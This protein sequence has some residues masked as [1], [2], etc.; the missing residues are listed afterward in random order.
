MAK[1]KRAVHERTDDWAQL[2]RLLK[3]PDQV[4]YELIRPVVVFGETAG[5]RAQATGAS[6]RT[7]DRQADRFDER[8]MLGLLPAPRRE[9]AE[10]PRGLP[11]PMRQ[12]IVDLRAEVPGMSL[13]EIA[14]VCETQFGRR[15][16]HHTVKKVL[17]TGPAPSRTTRRF[18]S[19]AQTSDPIQRRLAVVRLHA[20]GWRVSTIARYLETTPRTV[21]RTLER[22]V[23]E[24]FAGLA[25]KSHAPTQPA[26]KVTLAV[27]NEV[28]KLQQN[29]ELGEWRMHAALLQMG[30]AVS[31]R[32]CGRIMARNRALYGLGKPR[33]SP[34]SKKEM[35]YKAGRR[36]EYWSIDIRYIE[37]HQLDD[38]EPVFVIS[39][40]ENYSRAV[41]ASALSPTQDLLAVLVVVYEALRRCGAPE[42]IVSDGGA[43]FRAKQLLHAYEALGIRREQIPQG[44]PWTNYIE[45]HFGIMRRLAD[46]EFAR[47]ATWEEMLAAHERFV[48]DYNAQVHWAHRDRQDRRHSPAAVLGWVR[49][50]TYP[51]DV[52]HRVLYAVQFT[53]HVDRHGYIRFRHWRLYGERGLAG[54]P[55]SVWV[56]DGSLRLEYQTVLLAGY[57]VVL[58]GDGKHIRE[59]RHPRLAETRFRSPQLALF[60]L[61][62]DEWLLA[63]RLPE[64]APRRR[65]TLAGPVQLPLLLEGVGAV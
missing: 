53:R 21:Y 25:D 11:P 38:P 20:E 2:R 15:P 56:Y 8:G 27:A 63:L 4:V 54:A 43:V 47:A 55:V 48:R 51:E 40:L 45:S 9:P 10:D 34:R 19:Y 33:R 46:Y 50:T 49:G 35:P 64:Y 1:R 28:R 42:V 18:P 12:R 41:L 29:P 58:Q 65:G 61:G 7:I 31:P 37:K 23:A 44:Q 57:S 26:T 24:Q 60:H 52:L 16:S 39:I 36:H 3:W 59:V 22:W 32:T 14:D 5:E 17:A 30:I 6:E 13:H 62:P